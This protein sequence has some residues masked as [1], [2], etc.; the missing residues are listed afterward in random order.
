MAAKFGNWLLTEK[1]KN[2]SNI[3]AFA[4]SFGASAIYFIPNSLALKSL[5]EWVQMY[6][7]G[8]PVPLDSDVEKR[9]KEVLQ[10]IKLIDREKE[11][12]EFFTVYGLDVFSAGST[13]TRWGSIIGLPT[14][15]SYKKPADIRRS[16][17]QLRN[18][19]EIDWVSA[20]GKQFQES[21][22]FSERAQKFVIARELYF[23]SYPTCY[24]YGLLA[25][26]AVSATT[27]SSKLINKQVKLY[28][29]PRSL[30][31]ALYALTTTLGWTV[32]VALK[33]AITL[34]WERKSDELAA[35]LGTEFTQGGL[36]FYKNIKSR[37]QALRTLMGK[38]GEQNYTLGG[39]D[40]GYFIRTPTIPITTRLEFLENIQKNVEK[41]NNLEK[42]S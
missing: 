35:A 4:A 13:T 7:Y 16:T 30:R 9:T 3:L 32:F 40:A 17:I 39:N 5:K 25:A 37:N 12:F 20:A 1:G 34:Y 31:L 8:F 36:D 10:V 6:R 42:S 29:R 23:C 15:F 33:D 38:Y 27:T 22:L 28:D 21:M 24:V 18:V 2:V 14:T 26:L 41:K 19:K 11:G